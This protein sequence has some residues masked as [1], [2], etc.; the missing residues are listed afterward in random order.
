MRWKVIV[1]SE[2]HINSAKPNQK[3]HTY[4]GEVNDSFLIKS[5]HENPPPG[6][7]QAPAE[8]QPLRR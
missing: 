5:R 8:G 2:I 3:K 4:R 6:S 7:N 1:K